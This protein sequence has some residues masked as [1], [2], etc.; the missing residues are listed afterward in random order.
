MEQSRTLPEPP[1]STEHLVEWTNHELADAAEAVQALKETE[2]WKAIERSIEDRLRF[3]QRV[4]MMNG[5]TGEDAKYERIV[6]QWAGLRQVR[7]ISEG[8]V[9][10]GEEAARRLRQPDQ[11]AAN[12]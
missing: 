9:R 12:G 4:M 3:E 5:P 11:E 8:I 6:G 7:A 1:P 2:G 10:A